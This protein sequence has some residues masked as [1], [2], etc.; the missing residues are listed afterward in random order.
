M[1]FWEFAA[2]ELDDITE[3]SSR[4]GIEI[5]QLC[6]KSFENWRKNRTFGKIVFFLK[7]QGSNAP[8]AVPQQR[9][10]L[11]LTF[12]SEIPNKIAQ[13]PIKSTKNWKIRDLEMWELK[14][15]LDLC[16]LNT[17]TVRISSRIFQ[18]CINFSSLLIFSNISFS[19]FFRE[20]KNRSSSS[21]NTHLIQF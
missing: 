6:T 12:K 5:H 8:F 16:N 21:Q 18:N 11:F 17:S 15:T 7:I 20:D 14:R 3:S 9:L 2:Y 19:T 10:W 1:K 13:T 4:S